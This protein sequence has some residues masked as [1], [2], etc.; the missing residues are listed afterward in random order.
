MAGSRLEALASLADESG[1]PAVGEDVRALAERVRDGLF[2]VACVGQ[3]KR[4]KSTLLNAL[5]GTPV[6]PV[7]VVPV[8]AVVTVIRHGE[9]PAARVR[10]ASDGWREIATTDLASYVTEEQ[11]PE[12][13]KDVAAVEVFLPGEL[14]ASGMCLVDTP[15]IGSVFSGNTAATHA[16]VPHVDA[17]VVV[18]G[19]DPPI[20]ADE[21]A[22]V[23]EIGQQCQQLLVVLNKA[24]R[25]GDDEREEAV[26]FTRQVLAERAG[27]DGVPLFT[28]SAKERLAGAGPQREW[29]ELVG[30]LRDL[31]CESGSGLVRSAEERGIARLTARLQRHLDEQRGALLRPVA[32]TEQRVA[33]LRACV[34]EA[35]RALGDL[36]YLFA[37]E[38]NR[39][40]RAF[41]DGKERFL[42]QA[43]TS[44]RQELAEACRCDPARRGPALRRASVRLAR[45]TA[46]RCLDGWLAEAE[47]A[48][49]ELYTRAM[50]RFVALSNDFLRQLKDSGDAALASLPASVSPE[51][52]FRWDSRLFYKDLFLSTGEGPLTWLVDVFRTRSSS[53]RSVDR[54]ASD[55]LER[56]LQTNATRIENDLNER[57]LESRRR[58]AFELRSLLGDLVDSAT[59]SLDRARG[60]HARGQ[61]AVQEEIERVDGLRERLG[62]VGST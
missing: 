48:A 16:F 8:T 51:T 37:A 62:A 45:E 39:L 12:N 34:G 22:L 46:T 29:G 18:L 17:A 15:G 1:A 31:A 59:R 19:A 10:S 52:G 38:Q 5:V 11:N 24:D 57:V 36:D 35:E 49:E 55:Y 58:F 30:A 2:Y 32:E 9:R 28:V 41:A 42:Q 23:T 21:L 44:A 40:A 54:G 7:G 43:A 13:A 14:L 33:N 3:F 27:L 25:L 60:I 20:S 56:L 26:R 4:G 6:L 53:L 47:P 50:D 61:A